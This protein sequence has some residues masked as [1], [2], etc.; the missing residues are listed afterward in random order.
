MGCGKYIQARQV[1]WEMRVRAIDG[2]HDFTFGKGRNNYM[3]ANSAVVQNIN[4]RL[5]SFLGDCFFDLGAGIDW[6]N[7]L[8]AKDQTAL[9]LAISAVILN[10]VDVTGIQ[11][12][13]INLDVAR[14]L[15]VQYRVQTIYSRTTGTFQFDQNGVA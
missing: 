13:A 7:L 8:G 12:I 4:T 6:F 9:N 15:M 2:N 14:N 3:Q 10:T 1:E 11:Q 5:S